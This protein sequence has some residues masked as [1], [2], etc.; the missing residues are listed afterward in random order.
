MTSKNSKI[1]NLESSIRSLNSERD[2]LFDQLQVKQAEI[3][4]S[5][6]HLESLQNGRGELEFQLREVTERNALLAEELADTRRELEYRD[7]RPTTSAED[8]ARLKDTLEARY[9]AQTA[10]LNAKLTNIEKERNETEATLS[11]SLNQKAQEIESLRKLVESST[12]SRGITEEEVAQLKHQLTEAQHQNDAYREQL[13]ELERQYERVK[14]LEVRH[15]F[16]ICK[17]G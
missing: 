10:E 7:L 5:Q 6:S 16:Y 1:Q 11:K 14:E 9:A 12:Q 15:G 2:S 13:Q 8:V 17:C 4:S 3:E